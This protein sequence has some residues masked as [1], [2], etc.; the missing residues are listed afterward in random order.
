MYCLFN[1]YQSIL[2]DNHCI[3]FKEV[4]MPY[5]G[6]YPHPLSVFLNQNFIQ[7]Y[8]KLLTRK[9]TTSLFL[10]IQKMT[11]LR[12]KRVKLHWL[13]KEKILRNPKFLNQN[14]EHLRTFYEKKRVAYL[15]VE[16]V[17]PLL[18]M[19]N[20]QIL[21][22]NLIN[23]KMMK[24]MNYFLIAIQIQIMIMKMM[25]SVRILQKKRV[26]QKYGKIF[27]EDLEMKRVM[28]LKISNLKSTY[29]LV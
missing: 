29:L 11:L 22:M 23:L 13:L 16:K 7:I 18:I 5:Y 28:L 27:M 4:Q 24:T 6:D 14:E 25:M 19:K 15:K 20:F 21:K 12:L 2:H 26:N 17:M 3:T 1:F 9:M 8:L 10:M